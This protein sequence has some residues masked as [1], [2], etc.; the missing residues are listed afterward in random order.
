MV[1]EVDMVLYNGFM[2][3]FLVFLLIEV[4]RLRFE[5]NYYRSVEVLRYDVEVMLF[6][7][8]IFFG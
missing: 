5:N 4:I 7:V 1:D 3:R 8:E 2:C 6:N